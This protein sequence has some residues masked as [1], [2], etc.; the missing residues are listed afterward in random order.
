[1]PLSNK[2]TNK[3]SD[4]FDQEMGVTQGAILS[5][6]LFILK[7]NSI[8]KCFPVGVRGS[9]YVDDFC[10]CFRSKSLK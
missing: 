2:Q 5:V 7:I 3:L 6:T 10:I 9:L 1:V 4:L 8:V